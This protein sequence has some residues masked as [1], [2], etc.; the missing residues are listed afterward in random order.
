MQGICKGNGCVTQWMIVSFRCRIDPQY[1]VHIRRYYEERLISRTVRRF[2]VRVN[3]NGHHFCAISTRVYNIYRAKLLRLQSFMHHGTQVG[4]IKI[5]L[6]IWTIT[7][8][9]RS[10]TEEG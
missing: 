6:T 10:N 2:T 9:L 5:S 8:K 7:E 3:Y 1:L 4:C